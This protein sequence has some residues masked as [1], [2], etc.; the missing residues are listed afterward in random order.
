[1]EESICKSYLIIGLYLEYI[2][3]SYN[4]IRQSI[5]KQTKDLSDIS[6]QNIYRLP[7]NN[8]LINITTW[9]DNFISHQGDYKSKLQDNTSYPLGWLWSKRLITSV[10]K[11][12][13]I[14][15]LMHCW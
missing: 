2:R 6:S 13:E 5:L 8:N 4:S 1:M 9:K 12:V 11:D 10:D 14:T 7:I 15:N 3:N